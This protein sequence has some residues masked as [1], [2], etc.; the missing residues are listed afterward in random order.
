MI[1]RP[2]PA[3]GPTNEIEAGD[4][5]ARSGDWRGAIDHWQTAAQSSTSRREAVE[6]RLAW[7]LDQVEP[8]RSALQ[9]RAVRLVIG[10]AVTALVGTMLVLIAPEPGSTSANL[11]AGAAWGLYIASATMALIAARAR[12]HPDLDDLLRR[13]RAAAN[14][15]ANRR[16]EDTAT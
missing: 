15:L 13:A 11:L 10:A 3:R 9:S 12:Q 8:P 1:D 14:R 2:P 4:R 7:L 16:H 5:L 6:R